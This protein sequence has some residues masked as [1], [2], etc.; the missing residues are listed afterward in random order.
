MNLDKR[1][2]GNVLVLAIAGEFDTLDVGRF[3]A[4]VEEAVSSGTVRVALDLSGMTFINSTALGSL[5]REQKRLQQAGGDLAAA[6]L[7]TFA[8]KNF[9]LLGLDRKVRCFDGVAEAVAFLRAVSAAGVGLEGEHRVTF[10]FPDEDPKG[11]KVRTAE[12][13]SLHAEG[14]SLA[15]ENLEAFDPE[16]TFRVGRPIRLGFRLPLYHPT[17]EFRTDAVVG[18]CDATAGNRLEVRVAFGEISDAERS[19]IS[20]FVT[21]L[22]YIRDEVDPSEAGG[23]K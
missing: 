20:Q 6:S 17:H 19:A 8:K 23:G 10:T 14:L 15:L 12:L 22:R 1:F 3:G 2:E 13:R 11:A 18:N 4:E 9:Q 7:S 21:D 16:K 5:L